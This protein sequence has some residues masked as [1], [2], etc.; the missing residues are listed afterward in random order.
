MSEKEINMK[1]LATELQKAT[2]N[3]KEIAEDVKGRMEKGE[4]NI[5]SV[6]EKAD[7]ALVKFNE[8]K[9]TVDELEQ[10]QARRGE[11]HSEQVK[12]LGQ[13]LVEDDRFNHF[14]SEMVQGQSLRVTTKAALSSETTGDGGVGI[15]VEPDK[16]GIVPP[17]VQ[18]LTV[19]DLLMSGKTDGNTI[20]W[21]QETGFNNNADTVA[22]GGLK[23]QSDL[24]Y[25]EKTTKVQVIAHHMK[26]SKQI[27]DDA[28]MLQSMIDGRMRYGLKL[29]EEMQLLLGDGS[30]SNLHGIIPQATAF[31]DPA[32]MAKYTIIDQLRLAQLQS[33][34]AELPAS[35][36]VMNP[37]DWAKIELEKDGQGRHIIGVPQG[38]ANR[39]LWGLPVVETPSIAS[40]KFL[41]GAF[42]LGAQIFD[43]WEMSTGIATQNEDDFIKNMITILVEERLGLAVY[44]PEAFIYGDLAAKG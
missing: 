31:A 44:R 42:S 36:V 34:L 16:R 23:P 4:T 35:G 20:S 19:R 41:T 18:R 28:P 21:I 11:N 7:E 32:S 13:S 6:A 26:A 2:D 15:L 24:K 38:V 40:G 33:A 37:I 17:L 43:R 3:V 22:E 9:A 14:K 10:K 5:K 8:L 29:K 25:E 1:E 27:L 39:T 30:G 12:S